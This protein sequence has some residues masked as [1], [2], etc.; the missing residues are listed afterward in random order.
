MSVILAVSRWRARPDLRAHPRGPRPARSSG[1]PPRRYSSEGGGVGPWRPID[2]HRCRRPNSCPA[3]GWRA[4]GLPPKPGTVTVGGAQRIAMIGGT[5]RHDFHAGST[6]TDGRATR[7]SSVRRRRRRVRPRG[8]SRRAV[9]DARG[10]AVADAPS[11]AVTL[12]QV[13]QRRST[14]QGPRAGTPRATNRQ[15]S[16]ARCARR[17]ASAS[18]NRLPSTW[19]IPAQP[20]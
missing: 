10:P 13:V 8:A 15:G 16:R 4:H 11:T 2:L 12:L 14:D 9:H 1:R 18:D 6:G 3:P 5:G 19:W 7:R 17:C 20:S